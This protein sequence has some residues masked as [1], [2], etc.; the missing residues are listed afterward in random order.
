MKSDPFYFEIKDVMTQFVAAFNDIVI[1]RHNKYREPRSKVKVRYVYAP[2]QRVVHDLTNKARHLTLPVVAVSINSITRDPER[3]FNKIYGQYMSTHERN[4]LTSKSEDEIST[5][6][7]P[8]PVPINID[9]NMSILA[10]YQ[11]DIEQIISNFI[12]YNDPYIVISWKMPKEFYKRDVEIRSEVLWNGTLSMD[13][14]ETLSST[15]PYRLSCDTSFTVKSWLFKKAADTPISDIYK[16]TTNMTPTFNFDA[17]Y[18]ND[19]TQ[20]SYTNTFGPPLTAAPYITDVSTSTGAVNIQG[21]NML[22]TTSAYISSNDINQLSGVEVKMHE[23]REISTHYPAF[24]GVPVDFKIL[25]DNEIIIE[26]I[27]TDDNIIVD[28]ILQNDGGYTTAVN[29]SHHSDDVVIR[30]Q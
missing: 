26:S 17:P 15:E 24:T 30:K 22:N 9:V 16:I 14:P 8:Q 12:P 7:V 29:S 1:K 13:Y 19:L 23:G 27:K 20:T 3:I 10:R 28:I 21:Y 11:T 4:Y 18:H 2:K 5:Q 6:H 25:N